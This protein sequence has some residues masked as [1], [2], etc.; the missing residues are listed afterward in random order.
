[1]PGT[2]REIAALPRLARLLPVAIPEPA[3][4]GRPSDAFARPFYGAP[5]LAGGE[6]RG[7]VP[8]LVRPLA[9]A[10]RALH[11][12][13]TFAAV[14]E[15]LPLDA[16]RRADMELRVP[17]T[18]TELGELET[19]RAPPLVEDVL[20]RAERLP[21]P[22]PTAVCHGDLHFRQLLV[23]GDRLTGII[24]WVDVCRSDPAIDL[25]VYWSVVPPDLRPAFVEEYGAVSDDTLLRARIV[26][27]FLG[28]AVARYARA[29]G[30][31]TIEA[32]ALA[33]LDRTVTG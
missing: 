6:A 18:R 14:G 28:A 32:E 4:V 25:Q 12:P 26:A 30:L 2:E 23:D 9:A 3:F 29:E 20:V 5:Y 19:W 22:R 21:P 31:R 13:A 33:A 17:R 1:V 11:S 16:N 24:D 27:L 15:L 8:A 7:G 10:L